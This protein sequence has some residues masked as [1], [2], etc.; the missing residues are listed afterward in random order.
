MY[1][2][3][4]GGR[5]AVKTRAGSASLAV[6][7]V[8][9]HPIIR[10]FLSRLNFWEITS[11]CLAAVRAIA[12]DHAQTLSALVQNLLLSPAPLY[13]IA[14][15]A[16]PVSPDALGFS[17]DEK[18]SL[19]DDRVART[20][21][22]L[23]SPGARSLFFRLALRAIKEFELDT[24]RVHQDTT[25]VTFHGEYRTSHQAPR[26]TH[27]HNKD[28]RPDLK[29]L[30]FGVS[31]TADGAVPIA[32]EV[33]SGNRTDDTIHRSHVDHLRTLLA[34]DDFIYV[35]D[36]KLCTEKNLKH[37]VDYGGRFVT[38]LPRTRA[39]DKRFREA[40]RGG[41][42]A[43]W[44]T[45]LEL[46]NQRR[47]A[48]FLDRY[49]TTTRGPQQTKEGYRLVWCRSAQKATL[50][51][52][53]RNAALQKAETELVDL[54]ARLNQRQLRSRQ[55]IAN[56][57]KDVLRRHGCGLF[58]DVSIRSRTSVELRR[59]RRGRPKKGDPVRQLRKQTFY[60]DVQRNKDALRAEARVDGVFAL[61]T[62]VKE[63]PKKEV[64]LTYKYQPY[65]EKRHALLKSELEVAPVYIKK[66]HRA[67]GLIHAAFIAMMVDALIERTLRE[68]MVEHGIESLPILP[69]GRATKTPTTARL[70]EQFSDVAWYEVN[71]AG[72]NVVFPLELTP[73]QRKLLRLLGMTPAAYA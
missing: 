72:E 4:L 30:V 3:Q 55:S 26:I 48:G 39:E 46:P 18:R 68:A 7:L 61:V 23:V 42:P 45:F 59:L 19:N 66:P 16:Q 63:M 25:T 17:L 47:G 36:S 27:G 54:N 8:G 32:H 44:R 51:A 62:N 38:V 65:V 33:Y 12:P 15:W 21:D 5:R 31:V 71:H 24:A 50:D 40:L 58:L 34:R 28:H 43:R 60:L 69:E 53:V 49:A 70:L 35:A 10:H 22:A 52:Q 20:L 1:T 29:Q 13:R 6:H 56:R 14:E 41:D 73:L 57:V 37:I 2:R 11:G 9:A 64:L 67:A